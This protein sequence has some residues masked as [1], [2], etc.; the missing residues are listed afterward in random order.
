[1]SHSDLKLV[2]YLSVMVVL[3][4]IEY[5]SL[6]SA[7]REGRQWQKRKSHEPVFITKEAIPKFLGLYH[8]SKNT[9]RL[10]LCGSIS[11]TS[12]EILSAFDKIY[13]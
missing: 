5:W 10:C 6:P 13:I 2:A 9:L 4:E 8:L 12:S 11:I 3:R 1:M 7:D